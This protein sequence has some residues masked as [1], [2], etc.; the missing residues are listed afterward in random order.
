MMWE[1]LTIALSGIGF[2]WVT[3]LLVLELPRVLEPRT[4]LR[5]Y[6]QS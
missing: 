6:P 5:R 3:T 1:D 2:A 4:V